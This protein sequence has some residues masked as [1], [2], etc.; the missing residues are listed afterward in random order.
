MYSIDP[1]LPCSLPCVCVCPF[2]KAHLILRRT[3]RLSHL[4]RSLLRSGYIQSRTDTTPYVLC[5]SEE[6]RPVGTT[7]HASL[8]ETR[9]SCVERML[10]VQRNIYGKSKLR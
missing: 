3:E 6:A 5:R 4:C 8:H 1:F 7:W 10:S 2:R 9:L